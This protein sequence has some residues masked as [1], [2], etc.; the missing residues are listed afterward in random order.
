MTDTQKR[1]LFSA[2]EA[3]GMTGGACRGN[4]A[5]LISKVAVDSRTVTQGS[6]FVALP[7]ERSDGHEYIRQALERGASCIMADMKRSAE[8]RASLGSAD[9]LHESACIIFVDSTL[10]GL[11]ALAREHRRRMKKLFR[12]GV[13]GS[14]GKTTTK[15]CIGAALAPAFP[16]GALAMNEGNLNSDIGLA[17]SMFDLNEGHQVGVFEMGMNRRGEMAELAAIYEPDVAVITNIGNAHI[18]MIGSRQGIAEEKKAI[19]SRFDGRQAALIRED[20]AFAEFLAQDLRGT[21]FRFGPNATEGLRRVNDLGLRGWELDWEGVKFV[22][23]LPGRHNLQNALAALSVAEVLRSRGFALPAAAVAGGLASVRP[24]FGRSELFEG[25]VSLLRDCYN[26][27]PDSMA[28]AMDFC[29]VL[30]VPGRKLFVLG[31][32][33]ELGES[34]MKEHEAM[35]ARAAASSADAVFLFGEETRESLSAFTAA[36]GKAKA[37]RTD[38]IDELAQ[39][40]FSELRDGDFILV[41]ASRSLALERLTDR[42]F[43]KGFVSAGES[44]EEG[45]GGHHHAP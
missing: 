20:E 1:V 6:L 3:A 44:P 33:R 22:F 45:K 32:M 15:E 35:G 24:L 25:R 31:S 12:I 10:A 34:S 26:A 7:G 38:D 16:E 41:K 21:L 9:A 37:F 30:E 39:A 11:Q 19:F 28:A 42:L 5:A 36:G 40:V 27:N 23:P 43:E 2:G 4:L 18:G 29:D 13:T 17:L 14:S 8:L